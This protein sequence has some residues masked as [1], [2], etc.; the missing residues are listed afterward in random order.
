MS[1]KRSLSIRSQLAF[2]VLASAAPAVFLG[3][4]LLVIDQRN[5]RQRLEEGSIAT[6]RAM[7]HAIDRELASITAAAEV[8]AASDRAIAG[9]VGKLREEAMHVIG[10]K[11]GAAIVLSGP[12]GRQLMNTLRP[13]GQPLPMHGNPAQL[14][15][16][17]ATG[18]PVT[19]GLYRGGVLGRPV[20]SVDVPVLRDGKVVYD[21]SVGELPGRFLA[22]LKEQHLPEG[23]IGAVFDREGTI[24]AR[25]RQ[26]AE[27]APE[28]KT[29]E[30]IPVISPYSRSPDSGW[31]VALGIPE[32]ALAA[33]LTERRTAVVVAAAIVLAL[34]L[35]LAWGIGGH[36]ANAIR[37]LERPA[38]QIGRGDEIDV[39]PLGLLEA[40]E[41]GQALVRA[42][43]MIALAQHR[44]QH[45]PLTGLA[46]RALFREL[47]AHSV[48]TAKRAA[49]PVS[50]LFIDLDGFK[51]VNDE[52]GHD[53]GD[54]LLVAVAQRLKEA[55]RGSDVVA[56]VGGD[57]FA[58][59]LQDADADT[60]ATLAFR[61]AEILSA[62][63]PVAGREIRVMASIG[64]A[65]Y[66]QSGAT[67]QA[68]LKSADEEMY[69]VKAARRG[70]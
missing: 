29:L 61:L 15:E 58:M 27:G 34:G 47:A 1:P 25:I 9:D 59:L 35:A 4:L 6:A 44:A 21:L 17:F 66:P 32:S 23:W 39:P 42:G 2:L 43:Q 33:Q 28:G 22:I 48:E 46:N 13:L 45:D 56:R 18:R 50:V 55:A 10:R 11:I 30:G 69:R 60:A 36:I 53:A 57:E 20:M 67:A 14:R 68:L 26:A 63:Y 19:S 38:S 5:D 64:S 24:V 16:V 51:K 40:D 54:T 37:A 8:L 70:A 12:D 65:T 62:P 41:L 3:A 49:A 31:T 7:V 52:H